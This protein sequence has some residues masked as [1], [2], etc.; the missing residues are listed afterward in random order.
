MRFNCLNYIF[1]LGLVILTSCSSNNEEQII[2]AKTVIPTSDYKSSVSDT[3]IV[4][5]PIKKKRYSIRRIAKN[6]RCPECHK[7]LKLNQKI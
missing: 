1:F 6:D 4:P 3:V 7:F 5:K 2:D